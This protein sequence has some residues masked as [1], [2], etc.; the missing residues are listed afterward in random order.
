MVADRMRQ[1]GSA[2]LS[3]GPALAGLALIALGLSSAGGAGCTLLLDT[4]GATPSSKCETDDDCAK[5]PNAA[6]D[7]IKKHCVP[8]LPPV[9]SGVV[10]PTG[11]GGGSGLTCELSFDNKTRI[12]QTGL[13]GGL[14]PLPPPDA[15]P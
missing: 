1:L 15:G 6:C 11:T 9:D 14:R 4:N 5:F 7:D 10:A 3:P 12:F 2:V 8:R 13:D